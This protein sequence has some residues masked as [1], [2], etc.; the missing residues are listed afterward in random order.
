MSRTIYKRTYLKP[1][2]S[3]NT[4]SN[5]YINQ[6]GSGVSGFQG[7]RFQSVQVGQGFGSV[8][9][10][11]FL[12]ILKYLGPKL[13]TTG[14]E[15]AKDAISGERFVPSLKRRGKETAQLIAEDA[16]ERATRFA[17]TGS[18]RRKLNKKVKRLKGGGRDRKS[19]RKT[20]K[21]NNLFEPTSHSIFN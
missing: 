20:T 2:S 6:S 16:A 3:Q 18:G 9:K 14:V 4:F 8:L 7:Q 17:Q 5:Y 19:K 12:P 10:S 1:N 11:L 15:V 21:R 13:L